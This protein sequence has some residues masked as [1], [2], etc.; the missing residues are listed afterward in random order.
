MMKTA[1]TEGVDQKANSEFAFEVAGKR[2]LVRRPQIKDLTSSE[3]IELRQ[4]L[5]QARWP[6]ELSSR[7]AAHPT[8]AA[9]NACLRQPGEGGRG[10]R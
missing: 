8:P 1:H 9:R 7:P 10:L 5:L 4:F 6:P 2:H 3:V